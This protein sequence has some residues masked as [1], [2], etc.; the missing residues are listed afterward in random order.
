MNFSAS[1]PHSLHHTAVEHVCYG[2]SLPVL[3]TTS[4]IRRWLSCHQLWGVD[5]RDLYNDSGP[6]ACTDANFKQIRLSTG[7]NS[8]HRT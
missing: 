7:R 1:V 8:Q 4:W 6:T 2:L 5:L 3:S